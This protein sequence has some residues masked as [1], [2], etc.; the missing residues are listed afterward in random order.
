MRKYKEITA[1]VCAE[2]ETTPAAMTSRPTPIYSWFAY[3]EGKAVEFPNHEE[4]K[5]FSPNFERGPMLNSD[6]VVAF[7]KWQREIENE[8][9]S[10]WEEELKLNYST[11]PDDIFSACLSEAKDR[12]HANGYDEVANVMSGVVEFALRIAAIC[13]EEVT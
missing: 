2:R 10:I 8:I 7:D 4:A 6:Q 11:L 1:Q 3:K 9:I 12:G 5:A 13:Y